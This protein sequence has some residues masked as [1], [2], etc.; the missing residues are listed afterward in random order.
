M[1]T[2]SDKISA[3]VEMTG[4][5]IEE[6]DE[7]IGD[8][9]EEDYKEPREEELSLIAHSDSRDNLPVPIIRSPRH[10]HFS[11][12]LLFIIHDPEF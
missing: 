12:G 3:R 11:S 8:E 2:E 9:C 4:D 5:N 10:K 7:S 1:T 6:S